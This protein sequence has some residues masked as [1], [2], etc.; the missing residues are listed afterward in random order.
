MYRDKFRLLTSYFMSTNLVSN[1]FINSDIGRPSFSA[2][3]AAS[4]DCNFVLE[5]PTPDVK[6]T[7]WGIIE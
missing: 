4:K 3:L 6:K 5:V 7:H 2:F 1:I